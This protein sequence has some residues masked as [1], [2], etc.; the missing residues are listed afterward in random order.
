MVLFDRRSLIGARK[1]EVMSG[2]A[3]DFIETAFRP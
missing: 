3:M 1:P 2:C